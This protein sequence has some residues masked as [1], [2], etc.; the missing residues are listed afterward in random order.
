MQ[1]ILIAG[2]Y[3]F[4]NLGD[5]AVLAGLIKGLRDAMPGIE[6]AALSANPDKTRTLHGITAIKRTDIFKIITAMK[7]SDIFIFGGGSLIQD[8]TS[9]LSPLYYLGLLLLAKCANLPYMLMAQGVGPLNRNIVQIMTAYCFN[10]AALITV[11]DDKSAELLNKIGVNKNIS[12]TADLALLLKAD[13]SLRVTEWI[14]KNIKSD[15]KNICISMRPWKDDSE[16]AINQLSEIL[17]NTPDIFPIYLPM[18]PEMDNEISDRMQKQTGGIK[19]DFYPTP[20]EAISIISACDGTIAMRLH[21]LILSV[22]TG[23]P[24]FGIIYDPKVRDFGNKANIKIA[25]MNNELSKHINDFLTSDM[26]NKNINEELILTAQK[27]IR[28]ITEYLQMEKK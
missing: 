16:T 6:I 14:A 28:L 20:P 9:L 13:N 18:H 7:K 22:I 27:N 10:K 25:D 23:T 8:S 15:K 21:T 12:I 5:E 17:K 2:Y 24:A 11:R 3:G 19:L 26:Q 1:R 4:D